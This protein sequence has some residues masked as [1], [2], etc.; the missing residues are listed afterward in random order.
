[1]AR[2]GPL[3]LVFLDTNFGSLTRTERFEQRAWFRQTLEELD[4]DAS[5]RGVLVFAH[6]PP[7]SNS[8]IVGDA[9]HV[10]DAFVLDFGGAHKTLAFVSG[11]SHAYERFLEHGKVFVVSGGGGGPRQRLLVGDEQRHKDLF[12]GEDVR[13]FNF[14]TFT[15]GA[16]A[17]DLAVTGLR[18]GGT[19]FFPLDACRL[20]WADRAAR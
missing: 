18:K 15:P 17:I 9:H 16:D 5:V 1:M 10:Q 8:T 19:E 7:Y 13:P 11:H 20:P 2:F 14:L 3:G 12:D 6:H 4:R